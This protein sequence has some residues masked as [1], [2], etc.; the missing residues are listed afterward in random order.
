MSTKNE[1]DEKNN[2]GRDKRVCRRKNK[3]L[4]FKKKSEEKYDE[5]KTEINEVFKKE[6]KAVKD[7]IDEVEYELKFTKDTFLNKVRNFW[8]HRY[9][10]SI[11]NRP[12]L[13][14]IIDIIIGIFLAYMLY[15]LYEGFG[16]IKYYIYSNFKNVRNVE[17]I[18]LEQINPEKYREEKTRIESIR[19]H[20]LYFRLR[21]FGKLTEDDKTAMQYAQLMLNIGIYI[22]MYFGIPFILAYIGWI[23]ITYTPDAIRAA[24]GFF[25]TMFRFFV[26]LVEAAASRVWIIRTVL[27]WGILPFPSIFKEHILPWKRAY[28]DVVIDREMLRY[29]LLWIRIMEKY[30]YRPKRIYIEIPWAN[31]KKWFKRFKRYHVDLTFK[32]FWLQL[33]K[34][35]PQFISRPENELYSRINGMDALKKK[36]YNEFEERINCVATGKAGY[37]SRTSKTNKKCY[38]PPKTGKKCSPA[39]KNVGNAF[40]KLVGGK[41]DLGNMF[42]KITGGKD[43]KTGKSDDEMNKTTDM[44]KYIYKKPFQ[45]LRDIALD[46]EPVDDGQGRIYKSAFLAKIPVFIFWIIVMLVLVVLGFILYGRI[47]DVPEFMKPYVYPKLKTIRRNGKLIPVFDRNILTVLFRK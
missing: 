27:G 18:P 12:D 5:T 19:A 30:Y 11:A 17:G 6:K 38:C 20:D 29:R 35:Y 26:R 43:G 31:L 14:F 34:F 15:L 44:M 13:M 33:V 40:S 21:P 1:K 46:C 25:K 47:F 36:F 10:K 16:K 39:T 32:E 37:E 28:I 8:R 42:N 3:F 22:F 24:L 23:F 2:I 7:V 4:R 9:G 45:E 41:D